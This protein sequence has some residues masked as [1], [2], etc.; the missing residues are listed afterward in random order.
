MAH[1]GGAAAEEQ[2]A[3]L[4][5]HHGFEI[6]ARRWRG[7]HG[8]EIDLIARRGRLIVFVEVKRSESHAAAAEHLRPAQLRRIAVSATEFLASEVLALDPG[9]PDPDI[10]FD[11]ALLDGQGKIEIIQ[12]AHMFD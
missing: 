2:V 12:N 9:P 7:R 5:R 11:L 3:A 1:H 10:R 8:G 6:C 4:Y